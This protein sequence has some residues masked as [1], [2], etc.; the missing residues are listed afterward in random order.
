MVK[1][2]CEPDNSDVEEAAI[3]CMEIVESDDEFDD[4]IDVIR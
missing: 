4:D 1:T 3:P 2:Q